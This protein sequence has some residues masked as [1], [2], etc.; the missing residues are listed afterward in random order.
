[1]FLMLSRIFGNS[2]NLLIPE[3]PCDCQCVVLSDFS[4]VQ[5]FT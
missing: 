3:V 5:M 1:M 2:L 4:K